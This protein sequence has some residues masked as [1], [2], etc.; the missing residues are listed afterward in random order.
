[1]ALDAAASRAL[2]WQCR[3]GL[4]ELD[5]LFEQVRERIDVLPESEQ[6][7]LLGALSQLLPQADLDLQAWLIQGEVVADERLRES[8]QYLRTLLGIV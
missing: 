5:L 8:V 3:R 2:A 6:A 1:M 4:L 7:Q